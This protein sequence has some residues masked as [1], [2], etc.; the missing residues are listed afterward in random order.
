M[1]VKAF[2]LEPTDVHEISLRRYCP[3]SEVKCDGGEMSYHNAQVVVGTE[4]DEGKASTGFP[5]EYEGDARWPKYCAC[6]YEFAKDDAWQVNR[7]ALHTRSDGGP[8][9]TLLDAPP[10][11]MWDAHWMTRKGPDGRSLVAKLPNGDEWMID[12][13]ASNCTMP[14][15]K[16]HRCWVRHGEPPNLTVDK[17]GNTCKAGAGSIG[18]GNYHGF[19]QGGVF[20]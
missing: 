13:R 18:S 5:A 1:S 2:W 11:A 14:E 8:E 3:S 15:D 16:E 17:N 7:R 20:T 12:G 6:G 19:L 9:T 4:P 10:G